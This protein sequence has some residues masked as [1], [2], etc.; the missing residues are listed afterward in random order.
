MW[1][2]ASYSLF[3]LTLSFWSCSRFFFGACVCVCLCFGPGLAAAILVGKRSREGQ[4]G[5]H[6]DHAHAGDQTWC[7][8]RSGWQ[9]PGFN[10]VVIDC[11]SMKHNAEEKTTKG[12]DCMY[13]IR[14]T[15]RYIRHMWSPH[16][17]GIK[18]PRNSLEN[19][20]T[21]GDSHRWCRDSGLVESAEHGRGSVDMTF[22]IIH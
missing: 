17:E 8:F 5:R 3:V 6:K 20:D 13:N 15:Y 4:L 1:F 7:F 12:T 11:I 19:K 22:L 9:E 21:G 10:D 16:I 2:F 18:N 14:F